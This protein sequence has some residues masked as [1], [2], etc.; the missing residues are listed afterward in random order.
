MCIYYVYAYLRNKDS[1]T[2][3]AGT[4]YYIGKGKGNRA[5]TRHSCPI[6]KDLSNIIIIAQNL[7]DVGACALERRMIRWYGRKD[8]GTGILSNLTDGGEGAGK[9][10]ELT[11]Q[12]IREKRKLQVVTDATRE[13]LRKRVITEDNKKKK[14]ESLKKAYSEG[15]REYTPEMR[16]R[17][18]TYNKTKV[19]SEETKQKIREARAKQDMSSRRG[20]PHSA[21]TKAKISATKLKTG[22]KNHQ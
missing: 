8:L 18:V 6:P 3:K 7:T 15:R 17:L 13:K 22:T 12:K 2:A 4:P 5:I 16:A 19:M 11:K 20:V 10:S 1:Q 21:E 14:S 9:M